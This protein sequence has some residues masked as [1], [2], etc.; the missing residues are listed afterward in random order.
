MNTR[1]KLPPPRSEE[2]AGYPPA[3]EAPV[4][5]P[6]GERP[7]DLRADPFLTCR[8]EAALSRGAA[9]NEPISAD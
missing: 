7:V 8:A 2:A 3:R 5:L 1:A 9:A 4:T 6:V